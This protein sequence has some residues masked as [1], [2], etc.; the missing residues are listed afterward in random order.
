MNVCLGSPRDTLRLVRRRA[1]TRGE[2]ARVEAI[3]AL[4]QKLPPQAGP[5]PG[6]SVDALVPSPGVPGQ[7]PASARAKR[8]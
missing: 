7:Q 4:E 2:V 1:E 6:I 5:R 3:R 8:A